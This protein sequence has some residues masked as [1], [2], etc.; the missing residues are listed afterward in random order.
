[1]PTLAKPDRSCTPSR[2]RSRRR[3]WWWW[4]R[5][6][7]TLLFIAVVVLLLAEQVTKIDWSKVLQALK[8]YTGWTLAAAA[9]LTVVSHLL[10]GGF[11]QLGRR[12]VGSPLRPAQVA[13]VAGICYA[14]TLNMGALIGGIAFRY[15]LYSRLGLAAPD[16]T[17]IYALS[18][19]SNWL[20]YLILL[21]ALLLA[22][23]VH[24]PPRWG[25]PAGLLPVLGVACWALVAGYAAMCAG[26]G[27]RRFTLKGVPIEWPGWRMA[28]V[29]GGMSIANWLIMGWIIHLFIG[30]RVDY[31]TIL[32]V[33]LLSAVAGA[34][35]H[36]P[37][38]LGVLEAVFLTLLAGALPPYEILAALLAYRAIYYL[39]PLVP[40]V[41]AYAVLEARARR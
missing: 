31:P 19:L 14:F 9:G 22:G 25:I 26:V 24:V 2:T 30:G 36:V 21:G 5:H 8:A 16:I 40:A 6:A 15:R 11:D 1:M 32:G 12:Y 4:G 27:R 39:C 18:V 17:K 23:A 35:T 20:G 13:V 28:L 29:Q 37:A 10:F 38:G 33:M 7:L 41:A 34:L 3:S